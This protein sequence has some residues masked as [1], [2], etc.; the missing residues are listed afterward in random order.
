MPHP[1][2]SSEFVFEG[3]PRQLRDLASDL[4]A[5]RA[6]ADHGE[7]EP[8]PTD[9]GV[10]LQLR[11]LKRPEYPCPVIERVRKRFHSGR[12]FRVLVVPEVRLPGTRSND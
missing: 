10:V 5:C 1:N 9:L 6:A 7:R 8:R 2:Q 3:P 11:H 4:D 12:P